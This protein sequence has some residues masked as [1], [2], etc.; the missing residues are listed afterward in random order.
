VELLKAPAVF[1]VFVTGATAVLDAGRSVQS[2]ILAA[3]RERLGVG[4][5]A[6]INIPLVKAVADVPESWEPVCLL[7][8]GYPDY[9]GGTPAPQPGIP[10]SR[11]AALEKGDNSWPGEVRTRPDRVMDIPLTI[12]F[13][14]LD[15]MGHV[16]NATYVTLLEEARIGFRNRV[17]DVVRDPLSFNSVVAENRIRYI[18]SITLGEPIVVKCWIS[19]IR[20][21]SYRFNYRICNADTGELKAEAMTIMVGFDY[22]AQQVRPVDP[23]F[24]KA[25]APYTV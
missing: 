15:A 13:R 23:A 17:T 11:M 3:N 9:P 10:L 6:G 18:R 25:V 16:N 19:H 22:Q 7:G 21:H 1:A 12:R 5:S 4:L 20:K 14:D 8:V 24:M 2:F